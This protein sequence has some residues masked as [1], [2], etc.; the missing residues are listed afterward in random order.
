MDAFTKAGISK[1]DFL[2]LKSLYLKKFDAAQPAMP[3]QETFSNPQSLY[4]RLGGI[5]PISM[6]VNDFID[7]LAT[8]PVQLG[9]KNVV[10]SLTSGKVTAAGLKYLVTEQLAMAAG[11][12]FKYTGKSMKE[13]HKDL[14]ITEKE[15][16]SAAAILKKVLDGYK[17]PAKEQGEIFA[18]I[19]ASH[20]D[21]VKK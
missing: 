9:N 17:V 12:P 20:N 19:S 8:D 7:Q 5:V 3:G 18:A 1:K 15:W 10:K 16:Q 6:V 2:E 4:A 11:G 21:I 13:S 14:A